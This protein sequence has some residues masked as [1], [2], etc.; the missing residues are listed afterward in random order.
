MAPSAEALAPA[1]PRERQVRQAALRDLS[2]ETSAVSPDSEFG[3]YRNVKA[4]APLKQ[5]FYELLESENGGF[6]AAGN[7]YGDAML[8]QAPA[9]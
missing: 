6:D 7:K 5:E 3:G 4:F 8:G 1:Y 9:T 2:P